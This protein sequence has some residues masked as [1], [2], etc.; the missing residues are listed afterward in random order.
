MV[1]LAQSIAIREYIDRLIGK[2][3]GYA[4]SNK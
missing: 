1:S 2:K 4:Y 3:D